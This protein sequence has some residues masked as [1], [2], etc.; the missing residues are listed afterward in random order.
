MLSST[1]SI[2]LFVYLEESG[3]FLPNDVHGEQ[4]RPLVNMIFSTLN[5]SF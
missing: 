1:F 3:L 2:N 4:S 5:Q